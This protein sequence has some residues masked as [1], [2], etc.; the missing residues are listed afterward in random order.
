[1]SSVV[2]VAG[3]MEGSDE[4]TCDEFMVEDDLRWWTPL[5]FCAWTGSG[6]EDSSCLPLG[7]AVEGRLALLCSLWKIEGM[8]NVLPG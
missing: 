3:V 7:L 6:W 2:D 4:P 5:P 8:V 1:V